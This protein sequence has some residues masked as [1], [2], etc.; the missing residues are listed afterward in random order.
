MKIQKDFYYNYYYLVNLFV[1]IFTIVTIGN[2]EE[3]WKW[4][5]NSR[6][7]GGSAAELRQPG[8]KPQY[9]YLQHR[10]GGRPHYEVSEI[11][12]G[13]PSRPFLKPQDFRPP[14][15]YRPDYEE[16]RPPYNEYPPLNNRPNRPY[17]PNRP[18][19]RP[20]PAFTGDEYPPNNGGG[21]QDVLTGP[22]PSWDQNKEPVIKNYDRC[23]CAAKFNCNTPGISFGHCDVGKQYCCYNSKGDALD[24]IDIPNRPNHRPQ[25]NNDR[26]PGILVGPGGPTGIIGRPPQ[27]NGPNGIIGRPPQNNN[28]HN[29]YR[30]PHQ[31]EDNPG[32]LVGPGGPTG[33]IGR[34]PKHQRPLPYPG[35]PNTPLHSAENGI[36]VGPGGPFDHH[37]QQ[38]NGPYQQRP[39][40]ETKTN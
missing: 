20:N 9:D 6:R 21:T 37:E 23:K 26:D 2:C 32:I 34:P 5:S 14:A 13:L 1:I 28:H 33:I 36:L 31:N 11:Q 18:P 16:Q 25:N 19:A 24:G 29:D 40:R 27:N 22:V 3:K 38:N 7:S 17:R 8:F 39:Y 35:G 10:P 30:P 15:D 4:Q 12:D